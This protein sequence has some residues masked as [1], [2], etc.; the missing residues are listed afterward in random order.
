MKIS[1]LKDKY[2]EGIEGI[3]IFSEEELEIYSGINLAD[4]CFDEEFMNE[5]EIELFNLVILRRYELEADALK[6]E[7]ISK[8]EFIDFVKVHLSEQ[9]EGDIEAN[10]NVK[11]SVKALGTAININKCKR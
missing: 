4:K 2:I 5:K 11:V 9:H 1:I 10:K 3:E 7:G 8:D 6:E